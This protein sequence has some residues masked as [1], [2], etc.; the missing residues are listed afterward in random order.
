M[1]HLII[2]KDLAKRKQRR[3]S[4]SKVPYW[5]NGKVGDFDGILPKND[6]KKHLF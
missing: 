3:F 2:Q 1:T 5:M 6:N 4:L